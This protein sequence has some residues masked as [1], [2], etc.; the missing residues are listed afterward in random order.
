M[1]KQKLT[2]SQKLGLLEGEIPII[3]SYN[4][5]L[6][7]RFVRLTFGKMKNFKTNRPKNPLQKLLKAVEFEVNRK[8]TSKIC[9]QIE[10][11]T[12]F[13]LVTFLF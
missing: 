10:E 2:K 8:E 6:H 13:P 4:R 5:N 12:V 9:K 7:L 1:C 3:C 11:Q